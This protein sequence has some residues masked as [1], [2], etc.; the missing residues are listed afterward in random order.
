MEARLSTSLQICKEVFRHIK[1]P[2]LSYIDADDDKE[3]DVYF[4]GCELDE[5]HLESDVG[6][7]LVPLTQ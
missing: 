6:S 3:R 4:D 5:F 7:A 1:K 2:S